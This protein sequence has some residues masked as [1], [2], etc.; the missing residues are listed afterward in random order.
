MMVGDEIHKANDLFLK[1]SDRDDRAKVMKERPLF[2]EFRRVT[3]G[4]GGDELDGGGG[5]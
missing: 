4:S 5:I 3:P 2:L 1:D